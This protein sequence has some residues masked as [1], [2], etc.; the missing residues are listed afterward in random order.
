MTDDGTTPILFEGGGGDNSITGAAVTAVFTGSY[1]DYTIRFLADQV[2]TV[3]DD[4]PG[5]PDGTDT[6]TDVSRLAFVDTALIA[7]YSGAPTGSSYTWLLESWPS[8][9]DTSLL[10]QAI[11]GVPA[12][13]P[14]PLEGAVHQWAV[15]YVAKPAIVSPAPAPDLH[16][17]V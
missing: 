2:I 3:T 6:L 10:I 15:D 14:A 11:A 9:G 5:S 13:N 1:A 4:R 17:P 12:S 16:S 7:T 8:S